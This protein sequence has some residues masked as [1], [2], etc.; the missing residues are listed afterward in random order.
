VD[1]VDD[2]VG[3]AGSPEDLHGVV[4]RQRLLLGRLPHHGVA[5]H[6]WRRREVAGDGREVERGDGQHEALEGPVVEPVPLAGGGAWLLLVE[7]LGVVDVEA[8]EVDQLAGCVDLGL[9]DRLR[10]T[11]DRGGVDR[12]ALLPGEQVGC[13]QEHRG[14]VLEPHGGP[15]RLGRDRRVDGPL[16]VLAGGGVDLGELEVVAVGGAD[17]ERLAGAGLLPVDDAGR[18]D[19]LLGHRRDPGLERRPFGGAGR[20]AA[21]RLVRGFGDA[22]GA[23]GHRRAPGRIGRGGGR[24]PSDDGASAR[25]KNARLAGRSASRR[26]K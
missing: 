22:E 21:D 23:V 17:H 26:T 18:V 1:E 7:P 12:V 10:L 20:V 8:Q 11:E 6:R 14:P 15:V 5:E 2:P 16:H 3:Q 24:Q 4:G 9:V 19:A 13:P 25:R